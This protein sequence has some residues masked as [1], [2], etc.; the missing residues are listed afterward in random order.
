MPIACP[1]GMVALRI[2]AALSGLADG[3]TILLSGFG[4]AGVPL[5][6]IEAVLDTG[7]RDLVV[8]ANNAGSS[9]DDLALLLRENRVAKLIY[10]FPRSKTN[11]LFAELHRAAKVALEL[12]PQ[13]ALI[14][15][16][17][18]AGAGLGGFYTPTSGNSHYWA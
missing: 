7:A 12:V 15:R 3:S 17:R 11:T 2:G 9:D 14:E 16:I 13:G 5:R 4:G 10:S 8:V 18:Y 1:S 6:L